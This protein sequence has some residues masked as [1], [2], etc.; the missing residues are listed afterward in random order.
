MFDWLV[1]AYNQ[2]PA[3][4]APVPFVSAY[5][6]INAANVVL[7][8]GLHERVR[9]YCPAFDEVSIDLRTPAE[10]VA[11]L[12]AHLENQAS[13][14]AQIAIIEASHKPGGLRH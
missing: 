13:N 14:A 2:W 3:F 8:R 10:D 9:I 12:A 7:R 4:G 11:H 1:Q 6:A 5:A